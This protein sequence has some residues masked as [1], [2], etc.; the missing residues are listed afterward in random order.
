MS[1]PSQASVSRSFGPAT[2]ISPLACTAPAAGTAGAGL[3]GAVAGA[4]GAV[5]LA[6]STMSPGSTALNCGT[7]ITPLWMSSV[8]TRSRT[9]PLR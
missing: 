6:C 2:L 8:N 5:A 4:T 9:V 1:M 3:A 7:V